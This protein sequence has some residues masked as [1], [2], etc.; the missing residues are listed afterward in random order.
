MMEYR[1]PGLPQQHTQKTSPR[2]EH[3][4]WNPSGR[5]GEWERAEFIQEHKD[6]AGGTKQDEP[7]DK[8]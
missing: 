3:F 2:R 1:A 7:D 6:E 4:S 5:A 8:R